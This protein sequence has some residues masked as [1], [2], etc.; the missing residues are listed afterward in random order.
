MAVQEQTPL[1]EYTANGI[2]KQFDLE[3]DC[4]QAEHLIVS[5]D[6]QEVLHTDWY[7]SGNAVA[8]YT[9]PANGKQIKIQRNT[10]FNR[11]ADYQ[12]YNN[13]FRPPAINK[14]FDRIWW[15]LQE[16]G[17]A[18]WILSNR[19]GALKAYVD[20][21]DDELRAYLME[22][23]RKQG[24]A[25]DQL[26]EYY[27]YLMQR[28]AQI[29]VDKGW[30]ASFVVDG[31]QNQKQI[32]AKLKSNTI[33]LEDFGGTEGGDC[34][35]ATQA[36]FD[37]VK[38]HRKAEIKTNLR[39]II[40]SDVCIYHDNTVFDF[41][42]C[43]VEFIGS[44]KIAGAIYNA[45]K[46]AF[47]AAGG[48][49]VYYKSTKTRAINN[50]NARI[51]SDALLKSQSIIVDN[52]AGFA[53]G[54][55]IFISNGYCDMWRVMEQYANTGLPVNRSF[56]DWV[57]PDVDLW[58][59]EIG[60]IKSITGNTIVLE[61]QLENDYMAIPK[62]YGFFSDENNRTDHQ[63]WNYPTIE[64]LN[65]ASNCTF[66]NIKA[67]NNGATYSI[68]SHLGVNNNIVDSVGSGTGVAFE[69]QTCYNSHMLRNYTFSEKY[70]QSIRRGSSMCIM[71]DATAHYRGYDATLLIW[72]GSNLCVANNIIVEGTGGNLNHAKS[73][74]YFNTAWNCAGSNIEAKNV[75]TVVDTAFC[76]GGIIVSNIV[77]TNCDLLI[78]S[79][80]TFDVKAVTGLKKSG[81]TDSISKYDPSLFAILESNHIDFSGLKD[82]NKYSSSKING[83]AHIY[84][85]FGVKLKDIEAENVVLWNSAD[86]SK[87][88]DPSKYKM[89]V[90][91]S[92]FKSMYLTQT[93]NDGEA[94][95]RRSYVKDTDFMQFVN[96]ENTH[97][98]EFKGVEI[99][100]LDVLKS[101]ILR[102]SAF[103]RFID[104][105]IKNNT[106]GIDFRGAG[107][108][109]SE[110]VS[111]QVYFSNTAVNAPTKFLNYIDP[112]DVV[113]NNI[114]S[115]RSMGIAYITGL[116]EYP[117]LKTFANPSGDGNRV[118]WYLVDSPFNGTTRSFTTADL[119][120]ASHSVN[121]YTRKWLGCEVYNTTIGKFMKATGRSS[122]S[123]WVST[124]GATTITPV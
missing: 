80:A 93:Y 37:Y 50:P 92:R 15:K 70:G 2:A 7:L 22:E 113:I 72:E 24:V 13:S 21:R 123:S 54:D 66:K 103:T 49:E 44:G 68:I 40:I 108:A 84:K 83:R 90:S 107:S 86:D 47:V 55:F 9:A 18:D 29:A 26:D 8:F 57:R 99:M 38:T 3:F 27:N 36:C 20:D 10:P 17:V 67:V 95:T 77:G 51:T 12:S 104:S 115:P 58:R 56:Q 118:G 116:S 5:I 89:K 96:I 62:T 121:D 63:G 87:T 53:V 34:T 6:D 25:L 119:S 41:N 76:R 35:T 14:D 100:G 46:T 79:H 85:S 39:K 106:T 33:Y 120:S 16:L 111:S 105:V 124:D 117:A 81:Y 101:V 43:E 42:K 59:C 122:T 1:Q 28:L 65:G 94:Q 109:G 32:N 74:F 23:I 110:S 61:D 69:F 97:N 48:A 112:M 31:D 11:L 60:K 71:A 19:I 52:V 64:K 91:G 30:D 45:D 98:T 78:N 114:V 75:K 88:L 73:G 102:V 82:A 4:E